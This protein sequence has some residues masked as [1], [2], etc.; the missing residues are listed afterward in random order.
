MENRWWDDLRNARTRINSQFQAGEGPIQGTDRQGIQS[1]LED[2]LAWME[3]HYQDKWKQHLP[4]GLPAS[5][6]PWYE[7]RKAHRLA[8]EGRGYVPHYR[9]MTPRLVKLNNLCALKSYLVYRDSANNGN[10]V[11]KSGLAPGETIIGNRLLALKAGVNENYI[12]RANKILAEA[13]LVAFV[14]RK[15]LGGP[16]VK[17]VA[18]LPDEVVAGLPMNRGNEKTEPLMNRGERKDGTVVLKRMPTPPIPL[19]ALRVWDFKKAYE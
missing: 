5:I 10:T 12:R 3:D 8:T 17:R 1:E 18:M 4:A 15:W 9:D 19:K 2:Y 7:R 6:I 14:R 16:W 11:N 13:G